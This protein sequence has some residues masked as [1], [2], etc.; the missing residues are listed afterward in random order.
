MQQDEH[1]RKQAGIARRRLVCWPGTGPCPQGSRLGLQQG[2]VTVRLAF[3]KA[4]SV[5]TVRT[6]RREQQDWKRR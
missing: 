6:G 4:L 2:N 1:S 5:C 3:E